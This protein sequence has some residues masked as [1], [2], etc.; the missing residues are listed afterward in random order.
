MTVTPD[1]ASTFDAALRQVQHA[2]DEGMRTAWGDSARPQ[3][4][5]LRA[6]LEAQRA[7][8]LKSGAVDPTWVRDVVRRVAEWTPESELSLLAA[9]G[10]IARVR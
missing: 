6:D 9:L 8:A 4:Q 7:F 3:L 5:Q 1:L 2:H 10:A